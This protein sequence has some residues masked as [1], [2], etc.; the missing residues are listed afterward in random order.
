M[1]YEQIFIEKDKVLPG[2]KPLHECKKIS[3]LSERQLSLYKL[4][5]QKF[6]SKQYK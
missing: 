5:R 6:V 4:F 3:D 2:E 1:T